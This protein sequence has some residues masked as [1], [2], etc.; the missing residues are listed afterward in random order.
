[1]LFKPLHELILGMKKISLGMLDVRLKKNK[2]LEFEFLGNTF[3]VMAEQIKTLKIDVYE[4]QLR[5][6]QGELKQL[7]AQINPHFYMNSLNIIYN[8]A[9]LND[10]E[11]VKKMSLHLA[12][13]FRFIMKANRDTITLKEELTHIE[14]Y[15]TIQKIRFPDKLQC[16]FEGIDP[17]LNYPIAALTVQ[18]FVEN[19]IIH[20][21]KNR[22][23]LFQI[24]IQAEMTEGNSFTLTISDNGVGFSPEVLTKLQN[25]EPLNQAE[26][27]SLGIMNVIHRLDLLYGERTSITFSN[28]TE[29]SGAIVKIVFPKILERG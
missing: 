18:P 1:M 9:A 5:V 12:D 11:T 27:S 6:K 15:I 14:N 28:H 20:G 16:S 3:N 25:K 22:K 29:G 2:T 21:F 19:S 17:I 10:T 8:L 26:N 7:Q 13:Y 4:E 23:Q 24:H